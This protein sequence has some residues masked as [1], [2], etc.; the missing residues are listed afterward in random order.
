MVPSPLP[1]LVPPLRD[2]ALLALARLAPLLHRTPTWQAADGAS[3]RAAGLRSL[4]RR[5]DAAA[6]L[7]EAAGP[8][9]RGIPLVPYL[10][11][12]G[13]YGPAWAGHPFASPAMRA[14]YRL[15]EPDITRALAALMGPAAGK[16]G[17]PRAI[18]FLRLLTELAGA[19]T[20]R[21]TLADEIR[22]SVAAEY[23]IARAAK[24]SAKA[25]AS[26]PGG[27]K[28]TRIDLL[29]EW[30]ADAQGRRAVVVIEA[31][32]G[33]SVGEGQLKP[34]REEA[35]RRARGGPVA[36]V[37][38]TV[39]PDSAERRHRAW[40]AVRWFALLRRWEGVLA[41]AGD[42]DPE[43]ARVRAHLWRFILS[44]RRPPA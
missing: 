7:G 15:R 31:K 37:L 36:L 16:R 1:V 25:T 21:A 20:V 10:A 35:Q 38:L 32:L 26:K 12:G 40:A 9:V 24:R 22:P 43:F 34:Y 29:F 13:A 17:A 33:A 23:Q 14:S 4:A 6:V 5:A 39:V 11:P 28:P 18:A 8:L 41:A 2:A 27:S 30:T 44:N 3:V 42:D 19:D